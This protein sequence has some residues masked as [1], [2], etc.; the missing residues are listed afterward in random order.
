[1]ILDI[2][3]E[4][5]NIVS[6]KFITEDD[7]IIE[8]T[9]Q[10]LINWFDYKLNEI[11]QQEG[12]KKALRMREG[13]CKKMLE[14][15]Y[16][17]RLLAEFQFANKNDIRLQLVIG[18]QNYDALIIDHPFSPARKNKLEITQAHEGENHFLR[19]LMIQEKGWAPLSGQVIKRGTQNTGIS[20][21]APLIVRDVEDSLNTQKNLIGKALERKAK[22]K[23]DPNTSLLIMFD[24]LIASHV[25]DVKEILYQFIQSELEF[26]A[27]TFSTLYLVGSSGKVCFKLP[28]QI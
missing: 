24:D 25:P 3:K 8:R 14:E 4:I 19:R 10:E 7:L 15:L 26:K 11:Q 21:D 6:M 18:N 23:Y 13:L 5:A 16:P 17:L 20:V 12:G 1:M 28:H 27:A 9:P 2:A 22:K